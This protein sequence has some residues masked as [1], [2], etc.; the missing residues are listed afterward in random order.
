LYQLSKNPICPPSSTS[1][2]DILT[3]PDEAQRSIAQRLRQSLLLA[4][5]HY[6][7]PAYLEDASPSHSTRSIA[8]NID[9]LFF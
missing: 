5:K 9:R 3:L 2:N 1:N 6:F 4:T 7:T 8:P